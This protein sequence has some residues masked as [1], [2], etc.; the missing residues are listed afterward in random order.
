MKEYNIYT[1]FR[2]TI[3]LII[4]IFILGISCPIISIIIS[5][6]YIYGPLNGTAYIYLS[7][8]IG[9]TEIALIV[10]FIVLF[11]KSINRRH[12]LEK[13]FNEK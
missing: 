11:A 3:S 8:F 1:E 6:L 13:I 4:P 7:T 5:S 9:L 10:I 12:D 2:K